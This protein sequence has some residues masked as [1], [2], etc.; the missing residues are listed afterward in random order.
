MNALMKILSRTGGESKALLQALKS[1]GMETGKDV[2]RAASIA[3]RPALMG[4][5]AS[6]VGNSLGYSADALKAAIKANP[7]GAA[8]LGGGAAALGGGAAYGAHEMMEDDD[9][10]SSLEALLAKLGRR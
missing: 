6:D 5:A 7:R 8:A 9:E 3:R 2:G 4:K 1:I 10:E